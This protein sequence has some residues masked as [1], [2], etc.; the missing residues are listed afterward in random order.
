[1]NYSKLPLNKIDSS[2]AQED[3]EGKRLP[4]ERTCTTHQQFSWNAAAGKESA[5]PAYMQIGFSFWRKSSFALLR[6]VKAARRNIALLTVYAMPTSLTPREMW[7]KA[8]TVGQFL[9]WLLPAALRISWGFF[10]ILRTRT[11]CFES[12][13]YNNNIHTWEVNVMKLSLYKAQELLS[14]H[15]VYMIE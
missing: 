12:F 4:F 2:T 8:H 5:P 9:N 7:F 1:M 3:A 15:Y 14:S 6:K 13:R 10:L 11:F